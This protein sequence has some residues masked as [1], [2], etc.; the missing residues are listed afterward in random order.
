MMNKML[1]VAVAVIT[2]IVSVLSIPAYAADTTTVTK[3]YEAEQIEFNDIS[4]IPA[5]P[6]DYYN[7]VAYPKIML[8]KNKST[9]NYRLYLL[10]KDVVHLGY[11]N[12]LITKD[13]EGGKVDG[14]VFEYDPNIIP[15][16]WVLIGSFSSL[17][18][19]EYVFIYRNFDILTQEN[20][21]WLPKNADSWVLIT[22]ALG[23]LQNLIKNNLTNIIPFGIAILATF[24]CLRML[25]KMFKPKDKAKAKNY[26]MRMKMKGIK[27]I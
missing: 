22:F 14:K 23:G 20:N 26:K 21:V 17:N 15:Y 25:V 8:N 11:W 19:N 13:F 4:F 9:G 10:N 7:R 6:N 16:K 18:E 27:Y 12:K 2:M 5:L 24:I 1:M 3:L